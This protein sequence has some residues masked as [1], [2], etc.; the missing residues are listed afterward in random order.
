MSDQPSDTLIRQPMRNGIGWMPCQL[1]VE[2]PWKR[3]SKR[4]KLNQIN[5]RVAPPPRAGRNFLRPK[6][7]FYWVFTL[8]QCGCVRNTAGT[9]PFASEKIR[10]ICS[11][12]VPDPAPTSGNTGPGIGSTSSK[13]FAWCARARSTLKQ[14]LS[15]YSKKRLDLSILLESRVPPWFEEV[16]SDD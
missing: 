15:G 12:T 7:W 4:R 6:R 16:T 8:G 13:K 10:G 11:W 2:N 1:S 9:S 3:P 5:D 14:K